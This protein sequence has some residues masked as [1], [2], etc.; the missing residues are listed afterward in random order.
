MSSYLNSLIARIYYYK[1]L[2]DKT[3]SQLEETDFHWFPNQESNSIAMII[4]HISGNMLSRFTD[5]L[6]TDGEKEW[7]HRDA[8][9]EEGRETKEELLASWEK[10]WKCFL[11]TLNS[12]KEEDL[13]AT[14]NIRTEPLI[15]IDAL[16]RQLAHYPYHIGQIIYIAKMLKNTNWKNL[17]IPRNES[18]RFNERMKK[19]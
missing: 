18:N 16:N 1:E 19:N 17:S 4:R 6:T 12:L 15:V 2:A 14:I 11:L 5:F 8:E 13:P 9:F 3:F 7:R 10:G